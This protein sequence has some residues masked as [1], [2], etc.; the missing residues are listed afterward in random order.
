LNFDPTHNLYRFSADGKSLQLNEL[1]VNLLQILD[2][3]SK[4]SHVNLV[5]ASVTPSSSVTCTFNLRFPFV[6]T[7]VA[8]F[9][10]IFS[11]F[12]LE[13]TLTVANSFLFLTCFVFQLMVL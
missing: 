8:S 9:G 12:L 13:T 11:L 7:T 4:D 10:S 2:Y 3:Y 6:F 1:K 5:F